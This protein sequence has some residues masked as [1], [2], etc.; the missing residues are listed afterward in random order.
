MTYVPVSG[1]P[2]PAGRHGRF[3]RPIPGHSTLRILRRSPNARQIRF[4]R[5]YTGDLHGLGFSLKRPKWLK[6]AT[7]PPR[8]IRKAQ[9]GRAVGKVARIAL[10]IAAAVVAAPFVLP[11][12]ATAGGAALTAGKA[13]GPLALSLLKKSGGASAPVDMGVPEVF[14]ASGG[15]DSGGAAASFDA[16]MPL[17]PADAAGPDVDAAPAQAGAGNGALVIGALAVGA[18]LLSRRKG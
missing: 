18:L 8:W 16:P 6:R 14:A 3:A 15:G 2:S 12:L 7:T 11:A 4:Q 10:P 5:H 17:A 9:V 13:L 1:F